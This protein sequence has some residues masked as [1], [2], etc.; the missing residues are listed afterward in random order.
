MIRKLR[1]T[2]EDNR[3]DSDVPKTYRISIFDG[4]VCIRRTNRPR[5]NN[6]VVSCRP[7]KLFAFVVY[8]YKRTIKRRHSVYDR[9]YYY[10]MSRPYVIILFHNRNSR[11]KTA[12]SVYGN[13]PRKIVYRLSGDPYP[14]ATALYSIAYIV[15]KLRAYTVFGIRTSGGLHRTVFAHV[16]SPLTIAPAV[17]TIFSYFT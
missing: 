10:V 14:N 3:P 2:D 9:L 15:K 16:S 12:V 5:N 1:R 11:G 6:I 13:Y 8:S 7:I 17:C 4:T